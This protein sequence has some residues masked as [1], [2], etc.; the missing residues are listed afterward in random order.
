MSHM[1]L[2]SRVLNGLLNSEETGAQDE[3]TQLDAMRAHTKE[4]SGCWTRRGAFVQVRQG[5]NIQLL[6]YPLV[7]ARP[8][9]PRDQKKQ[10]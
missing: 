6:P 7:T 5:P 9:V 2:V 4:K 10:P 8:T 3:S 1:M